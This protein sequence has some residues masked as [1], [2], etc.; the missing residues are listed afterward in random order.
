MRVFVG[1]IKRIIL[2]ERENKTEADKLVVW[3]CICVG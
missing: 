1:Q 2:Y 3:P